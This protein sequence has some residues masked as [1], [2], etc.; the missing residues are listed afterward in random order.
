MPDY[1]N[2]AI[3]T[4]LYRYKIPII[5]ATP[6]TVQGYGSLVADPSQHRIEITR[7]P[8]QGTRPVDFGHVTMFKV[9][10]PYDSKVRRI[11]DFNSLTSSK[12]SLLETG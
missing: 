4:G 9:S 5:Q 1:L 10:L 11:L 7:W 6:Q 8:A 2:P 12:S 3:P